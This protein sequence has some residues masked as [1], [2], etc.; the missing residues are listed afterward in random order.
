[1]RLVKAAVAALLASL[2]AACTTPEPPTSGAGGALVGALVGAGAPPA[3]VPI[4]EL[5]Q[6][7]PPAGSTDSLRGSTRP[8]AARPVAVAALLGT[9]EEP[10]GD[11]GVFSLVLS[12]RGPRAEALCAASLERLDLVDLQGAERPRYARRP[13]FWMVTQTGRSLDA[14]ADISCPELVTRLDVQRAQAMGGG[15]DV[16]PVLLAVAERNGATQTMRW[17]LSA[18]PVSEFPRATRIWTELLVGDPAGWDDRA[19]RIRWRE[20]ARAF[21][22]RY[23]EP[24]EGVVGSRPARAEVGRP[25]VRYTIL[26]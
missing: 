11:D 4:G 20:S 3:P 24:L 16:G 17:D 18:I 8:I 12:E 1:M 7:A 5:R 19:A 23:G 9:D 6:N 25:Q 13:V 14:Q 2:A 10:T 15:G 21:L 26:R 22:I